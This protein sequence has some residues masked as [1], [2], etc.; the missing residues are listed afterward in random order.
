MQAPAMAAA[1]VT[2]MA[3]TTR[4]TTAPGTT[5]REYRITAATTRSITTTMDIMAIAAIMVTMDITDIMDME[6]ACISRLVSRWIV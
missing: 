3:R 1:M 5:V 6:A 2:G 4:D